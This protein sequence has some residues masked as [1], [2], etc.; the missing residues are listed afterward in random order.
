MKNIV[1]DFQYMVNFLK[2]RDYKLCN[3][4]YFKPLD[5]AYFLNKKKNISIIIKEYTINYDTEKIISDSVNIRLELE[6]L[7][8]NYLNSYMLICIRQQE[9]DGKQNLNYYNTIDWKYKLE[10]SSRGIRKYIIESHYDLTRI[11]FLDE[12]NGEDIQLLEDLSKQDIFNTDK[13]IEAFINEIL[14]IKRD[15]KVTRNEI[16]KV[17][18]EYFLL[19]DI[20]YEDN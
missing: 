11:I 18:N 2:D 4:E 1:I 14:T 10:R 5:C 9:I 13:D 15:K 8:I 20:S 3:S 12:N 7:D 17:I 19:E 16:L 6:K